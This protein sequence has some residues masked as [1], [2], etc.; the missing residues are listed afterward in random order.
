MKSIIKSA[1]TV[2]EAVDLGLKELGLERSNTEIE[3]IQ[4]ATKGFLGMFGGSDAVVK[5]KEKEK[6][7]INLDDIFGD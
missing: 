5:I 1:K 2:E 6:D 7:S 4:E 3:V